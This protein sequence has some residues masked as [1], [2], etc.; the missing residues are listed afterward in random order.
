MPDRDSV[1]KIVMIYFAAV[2]SEPFRYKGRVFSPKPLYVSPLLLRGH[3]CPARCGGCCPRFSLDYLPGENLGP[4]TSERTVS[5]NDLEIS[6]ISDMQRTSS[7]HY[8]RHLDRV[9]GRCGIYAA[10]PFS[11]DFELIR[12][13]HYRNRTILTQ[14]LFGRGWA[15]KRVDGARGAQCEMLPATAFT[16]EQVGRKL[17]RLQ[18]WA[19]H[20]GITTRLPEV[21]Q[22]VDRGGDD[23]PLLL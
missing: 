14:K 9:T 3:T 22:W 5:F 16:V 8:C 11:C 17:L 7:E 2:T 23:K 15:M 6:L 21:I 18:K 19:D 12:F 13:C 4:N 20:F 1:D 10:R